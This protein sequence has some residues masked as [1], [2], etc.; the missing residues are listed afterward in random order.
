M[1]P[2]RPQPLNPV[3]D[4]ALR[5]ICMVGLEAC[6]QNF[7]EGR[8]AGLSDTEILQRFIGACDIFLALIGGDPRS[9]YLVK[10]ASGLENCIAE[11]GEI[12]M[13]TGAIRVRDF[14]EAVAMSRIFGDIKK[15]H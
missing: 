5:Q 2:R 1:R 15:A 12:G 10:G 14:E 7:A 8:A 9:L 6:R 13:N 4:E 11:G 3:F